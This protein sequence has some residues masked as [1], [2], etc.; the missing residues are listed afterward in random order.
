MIKHILI[1]ILR[2]NTLIEESLTSKLSEKCQLVFRGS[3]GDDAVMFYQCGKGTVYVQ[4][5][6]NVLLLDLI[7]SEEVFEEMLEVFPREH[8]M[9]RLV[10]RGIPED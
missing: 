2:G 10:E 3:I 7:D 6:N 4:K 1:D 9:I 8:L 5:R